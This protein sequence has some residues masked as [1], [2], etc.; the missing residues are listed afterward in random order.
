MVKCKLGGVCGDD[1]GLD[2]MALPKTY[3]DWNQ[4]EKLNYYQRVGFLKEIHIMRKYMPQLEEHA[5]D[6][7]KKVLLLC[8][9][10]ELLIPVD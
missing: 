1:I 7:I 10:I 3:S 9:E 6:V 8:Q 4:W 5:P 2:G